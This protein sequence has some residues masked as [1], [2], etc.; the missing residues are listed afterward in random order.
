MSAENNNGVPMDKAKYRGLK[1]GLRGQRACSQAG[2][3]EFG[4]PKT[5]VRLNVAVQAQV[6]NP[7]NT[8]T[9]RYEAQMRKCSESSRDSLVHTGANQSSCPK[10]GG[11]IV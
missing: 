6:I 1:R 7:R 11:R 8:P 2:G 5:H 10:E 3:P 4:S 9:V